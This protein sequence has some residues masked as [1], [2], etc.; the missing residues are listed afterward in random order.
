MWGAERQ[1]VTRLWEPVGVG[2]RLTRCRSGSR[3]VSPTGRAAFSENAH[4]RQIGR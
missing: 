2:P 3:L 1:R 4:L